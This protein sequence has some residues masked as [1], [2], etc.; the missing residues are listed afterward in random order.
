[1]SF[2]VRLLA[3]LFSLS[4]TSAFCEELEDLPPVVVKTVPQSGS[5]EVEAGKTVIEVTFS[6]EMTDQSWSWAT[7]WEGSHPEMIGKPEYS[8]DGRTCSLDVK[9]E[10]GKTYGFW[11]N[12]KKFGNFKDTKGKS[13]VPYLLVFRT[14]Q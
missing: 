8:E 6:K 10:A 9:L 5:E 7:A 2:P 1:M 11:L 4:L 14:A 12:S 13:A 3:V